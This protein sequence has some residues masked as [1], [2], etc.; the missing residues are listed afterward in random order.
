MIKVAVYGSLRAGFHNHILLQSSKLIGSER[1]SGFDMYSLG[2][3]PAIVQ[4][5]GDI[6][7]EMYEVNEHTF[8][9]LDRLEG[10]PAFYDRMLVETSEGECWIYFQ[11]T[12]PTNSK[13]DSGD[14]YEFYTS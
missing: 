7:V 13:I 5:V 2:A 10:F 12:P 6:T 1:I 3:F 14:W 11:H 9:R 4:G 8:K